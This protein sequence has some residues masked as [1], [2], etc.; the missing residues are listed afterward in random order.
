[1]NR[2]EISK[3]IQRVLTGEPAGPKMIDLLAR[4]FFSPKGDG[5][6]GQT[7]GQPQ[8]AQKRSGMVG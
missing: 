7:E 8:Q 4:L 3:N 2:T 1:M 5:F 6:H